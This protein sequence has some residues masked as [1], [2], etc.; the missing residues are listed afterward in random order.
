MFLET[1]KIRKILIFR[2]FLLIWRFADSVKTDAVKSGIS[3]WF[4]VK[5]MIHQKT[6]IFVIRAKNFLNF[7]SMHLEK[8]FSFCTLN[9]TSKFF[10]NNKIKIIKTWNKIY[11]YIPI[12]VLGVLSF[13][14]FQLSATD[15]I[16]RCQKC[17]ASLED[18]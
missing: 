2:N 3:P 5:A 4:I 10:L 16:P 1:N 11:L 9:S 8:Y 14:D 18:F 7:S 15:S 12:E 13:D 6:A 17:C